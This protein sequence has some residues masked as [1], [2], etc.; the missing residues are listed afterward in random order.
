MIRMEDIQAL[1]DRIIHEFQPQRIILFGSHAWG[2]PSPDS[3]VDLLVILPFEGKSWQMASR[4]R[5]RVCPPFPLDLLARTPE[6]V[7][8]RLEQGDSFLNE[9]T[10]RGIVLHET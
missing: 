6:Q 5:S 7:Y 4:I 1:A 10:S 8:A 2:K 3:D 9:V